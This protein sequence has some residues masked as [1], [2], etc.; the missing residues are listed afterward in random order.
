MIRVLVVDD[1]PFVRQA[2]ARM[3]GSAPDIQ[4]VGTAV[5]GKE[6]WRRSRRCGPTW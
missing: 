3:L 6:G 4:V 2:L 1:S 5:D